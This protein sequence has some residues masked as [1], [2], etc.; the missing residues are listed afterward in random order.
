MSDP[1]VEATQIWLNQT[2]GN[3]SGYNIIPVT[4]KTGWT[5]IYALRRALQIELGITNTSDNFGPTTT[6]KFIERFPN[7]VLQQTQGDLYQDN[8][9]AIIQGALWCK[10]YSVGAST[11]TRHFYG[12]T[13]D[14]IRSMKTD[15]GMVNPGSEVTVGVMKALLSMNQYQLVSG[16]SSMIR[17][18]QQELNRRFPGYIE[19]EPCDGIYGRQMNKSMIIAL[20]ALEGFS[21]SQATGNFGAGTKSLLPVLPYQGSTY[22]SETIKKFILLVRYAL[23][24]NGYTSVSLESEVYDSNL[25]QA[26]T[27]FQTDMVLNINGT[28]DVDTWMSLLL[29][30]GNPDRSCTACDTRFEMTQERINYLL[31]NGYTIVG[32]YLTGGTFKQ[33]RPGEPQRILNSGLKF[34][35]IFQESG[36]EISYFSAARGTIDALSAVHA[37]K[38]HGIPNNNVIYFAVDLDVTDAQITNYILPY[39]LSIKTK[40]TEL[41]NMFKIGIYGTRNACSRIMNAGYATTCFVSDMSTGY[42]GNMGFSIPANWNFDQFAEIQVVTQSGTWD[43]DKVAYSG[44]FST[45]ESLETPSFAGHATIPNNVDKYY[46]GTLKNFTGDSLGPYFTLNSDKISLKINI[47]KN[48]TLDRQ[49]RLVTAIFE[50]GYDYALGN[51]QYLYATIYDDEVEIQLNSFTNVDQGADYRIR[52]G[53][54]QQ[55]WEDQLPQNFSVDMDVY[56]STN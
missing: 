45:V 27:D 38:K 1:M 30:K 35:P 5:T 50:Y 55:E 20:Q 24:C 36:S 26:V 2:Y 52:Y 47:K 9:Y 4:G 15:A 19:Y 14:A 23:Y 22:S 17:Y 28:V 44:K 53:I 39:F 37:A 8:V 16:G 56:I 40:M 6:A 10:G 46:L 3:N 41:N 34:F 51:N 29:S 42:S 48:T 25:T 32:R 7:G 54:L 33:L 13:G 12:G 49:Y 21:I 11:I 43:L 31:T 18:I